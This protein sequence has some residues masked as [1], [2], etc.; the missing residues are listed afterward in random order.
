MPTEGCANVTKVLLMQNKL[1]A[2]AV[3]SPSWGPDT[4]IQA[5]TTKLMGWPHEMI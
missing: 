4:M 2:H 3:L 1:K 5:S